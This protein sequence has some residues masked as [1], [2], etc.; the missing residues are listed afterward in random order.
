MLVCDWLTSGKTAEQG[1]STAGAPG[2][3]GDIT[4]DCGR[5]LQHVYMLTNAQI[6][7]FYTELVIC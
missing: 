7:V 4:G 6:R 5:L 1:T 3:E 2:R